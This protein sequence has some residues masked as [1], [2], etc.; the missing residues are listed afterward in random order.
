MSTPE[1][2][3]ITEDEIKKANVIFHEISSEEIQGELARGAKYVKFAVVRV[4]W[5]CHM[6]LTKSWLSPA[7]AIRD[8]PDCVAIG[9]GE[10]HELERKDVNLLPSLEEAY[11]TRPVPSHL[12]AIIRKRILSY[13]K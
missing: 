11:R 1:N 6:I 9:W 3:S 13:L 5:A 10:I 4:R 7:V 12:M 8:I 2:S